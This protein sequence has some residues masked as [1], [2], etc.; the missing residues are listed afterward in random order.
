MITKDENKNRNYFLVCKSLESLCENIFIRSLCDFSIFA[1]STEETPTRWEYAKNIDVIITTTIFHRINV[2][3]CVAPKDHQRRH[4]QPRGISTQRRF[5]WML[6]TNVGILFIIFFEFFSWDILLLCSTLQRPFR[7]LMVVNW[8]LETNVGILL[9][10]SIIVLKF[11]SGIFC[12]V[13][14]FGQ[15][16]QIVYGAPSSCKQAHIIRRKK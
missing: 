4:F 10:I 16:L 12:F 2:W 13:F 3:V 5:N 9:V 11:I 14:D 8:M 15:C 6:E 1:M 7:E